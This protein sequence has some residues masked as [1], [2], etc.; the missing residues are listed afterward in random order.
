MIP[1]IRCPIHTASADAVIHPPC[2]IFVHLCFTGSL[3]IDGIGAIDLAPRDRDWLALYHRY[4]FVE[5]NGDR[6]WIA[7]ANNQQQ[8]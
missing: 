1:D 8:R 3:F 2:C 7:A 4:C 6:W 5:W